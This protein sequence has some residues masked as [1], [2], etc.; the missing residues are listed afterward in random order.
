MTSNTIQLKATNINPGAP[1]LT[2]SMYEWYIDN[3]IIT[4]N[5][6]DTLIIDPNKLCIGSHEISLRI[7]NSCGSWSIK[8]NK[9]IKIGDK[10]EKTITVVVDQPIVQVVIVL[11]FSGTI[12]ATVTDQISHPIEGVSF[13]LDDVPTGLTSDQDGKVSIPNVPYGTHTLE[14]IKE[15]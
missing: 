7:Q 13:N 2:I 4:D 9:I 10:M 1:D 15:V 5:I 11:D 12:E 8:Y 3:N 6:T 14:A